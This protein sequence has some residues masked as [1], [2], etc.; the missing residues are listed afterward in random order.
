MNW[1]LAYQLYIVLA[2]FV[3]FVICFAVL[4]YRVSTLN[5]KVMRLVGELEQNEGDESHQIIRRIIAT[6]EKIKYIEP[7][8]EHVES[9]GVA[10]VQNVGFVRFNPFQDT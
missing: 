9:I 8:L 3:F 1:I 2:L 6:E 10:S 7:R 5:K 4:M